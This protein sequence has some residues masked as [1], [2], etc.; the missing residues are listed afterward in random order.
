MGGTKGGAFDIPGT[1]A[2]E[3]LRLP[4]NPN[5]R[6]NADVLRPWANGRDV[7]QRSSDKWII[8]FGTTMSEEEAAFYEA[9]FQYLRVNVYPE[10]QKNR[11]ESYRRLWWRFVEPRPAMRSALAGLSRYIGTAVY[12]KHRLFAWLPAQVCPD[13]QLIV[14]AREDDTAFGILHSRFHELW[15]LRLCSWLGVGNDPRYTPSSTFET[16]PFPDRLTLDIA[17]SQTAADP[18]ASA[19]ADAAR[20]IAEARDRWLNPP[21]LVHS[22]AEVAPGHPDRLR[23]VSAAAAEKLR[24]LTLTNLYNARPEWLVN[25]HRR[26]DAAVAGAYG[27]PADISDDDALTRLLELNR[28][29]ASTAD[30]DQ[31]A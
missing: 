4:N 2:R 6:P 16:F 28:M 1:L 20:A 3:W 30:R 10:R 14:I 23:P 17:P 31:A 22:A 26:L 13:H 15:S 7:T 24:K 11:R 8:D 27:W 29:R 5:Q 9:P 19:I 12:G 21:E 25:L 18:R